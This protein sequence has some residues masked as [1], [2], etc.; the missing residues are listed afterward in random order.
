[1]VS[2]GSWQVKCRRGL[3]NTLYHKYHTFEK[4]KSERCLLRA[5]YF[6]CHRKGEKSD[7]LDGPFSPV[8][9]WGCCGNVQEAFVCVFPVH[10]AT[11]LLFSPVNSELKELTACFRQLQE[12]L[13]GKN[14]IDHNFF[15]CFVLS[16][17]FYTCPW[18]FSSDSV[19]ANRVVVL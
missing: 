18:R 17:S 9:S 7:L 19:S 6:P 2:H 10:R 3:E 1:M 11:V 5:G 14:Y 16:N 13:L 4:L 12:S 15:L 8:H